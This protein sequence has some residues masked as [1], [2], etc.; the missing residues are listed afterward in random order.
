MRCKAPG[1]TELYIPL[2]LVKPEI[3]SLTPLPTFSFFQII[4]SPC[5]N[6]YF[7]FRSEVLL[8][9]LVLTAILLQVGVLCHQLTIER[10]AGES[11]TESRQSKPFT[12]RRFKK[13]H[14]KISGE[15]IDEKTRR[16]ANASRFTVQDVNYGKVL[17][18]AADLPW[19]LASSW[20]K[21]ESVQFDMSAEKLV[22]PERFLDAFTYD[23][24]LYRK[25]Y[26]VK[27]TLIEASEEE[28]ALDAEK[29][30]SANDFSNS[31]ERFVRS[32]VSR[33]GRSDALA[34]IV[35]VTVGMSDLL[36]S[37]LQQNL[38]N[39]GLSH[40]L[41]VSGF[42]VGVVYLLFYS[43]VNFLY[44]RFSR[45][46]TCCP[47]SYV[48]A[49]TASLFALAYSYLVSPGIATI[50]ALLA[51]LVVICGVLLGRRASLFSLYLT[52]MFLVVVLW[53][54]SFLEASFQLTFSALLG[55][56]CARVIETRIS[57]SRR[58][59][60]RIVQ[61]FIYC[62][63]AWLFTAPVVVVWFKS[64]V[65]LS[66]LINLIAI[67]LFSWI[68]IGLSLVAIGTFYLG[69]PFADNLL[70]LN[71]FLVDMILRGIEF[72]DQALSEVGFG[73]VK[74]S[75]ATMPLLLSVFCLLCVTSLFVVLRLE[76]RPREGE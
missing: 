28:V 49:V 15:I 9:F 34:V 44:S 25:G 42:H 68:G 56:I 14:L 76:T 58:W 54:Y 32:L 72:I 13:A 48:S 39:T 37:E 12:T 43:L 50:R 20:Q 59:L 75:D 51:L 60:L 61:S 16:I 33:F 62:F 26:Q 4:S 40:L 19:S 73:I 38:R 8:L 18:T 2:A 1:E 71:I 30:K 65:P 6:L 24:S 74:I 53:P 67:P 36:S 27:G 55:L 17:V 35:S 70:R 3:L 41:V 22:P 23:A 69:I 29:L 57:F 31:K 21:G 52:V 11:L 46:V 64:V 63:F 7:Q 5:R 47:S 45:A 10:E 66:A